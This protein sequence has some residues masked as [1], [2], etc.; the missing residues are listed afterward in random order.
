[1]LYLLLVPP[2]RVEAVL[3]C[4]PAFS[5]LWKHSPNSVH[6]RP[7]LQLRVWLCGALPAKYYMVY[8]IW[9]PETQVLTA[10]CFAPALS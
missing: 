8:S 5:M 4:R 7:R 6:L 2:L 9:P 3:K 10:F 1:M